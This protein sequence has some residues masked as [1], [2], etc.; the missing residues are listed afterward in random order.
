MFIIL[1][2]ID[3]LSY[4]V[5]QNV[6]FLVTKPKMSTYN[7]KSSIYSKWNNSNI[8]KYIYSKISHLFQMEEISWENSF[9]M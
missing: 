5:I 2:S 3:Y 6:T 8:L 4:N 1:L 9:F 7:P